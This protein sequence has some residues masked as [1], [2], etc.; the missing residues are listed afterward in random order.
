MSDRLADLEKTLAI[1]KPA[2]GGLGAASPQQEERVAGRGTCSRGDIL[3]QKGSSSQY[4]SEIILS[5]VMK[6]VR[7]C[8]A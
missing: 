3:V 4:F 2:G 6:E 5:N 1:G 8:N 7:A